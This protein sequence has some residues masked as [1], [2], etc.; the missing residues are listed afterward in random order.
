MGY[1]LGISIA[2]DQQ[3]D[4]LAQ[5]PEYTRQFLEGEMPTLTILE[6]TGIW[7]FRRKV[8]REVP[9]V[10]GPFW[11]VMRPISTTLF[12]R[13]GIYY[14]LNGTHANVDEITNFPHVG[15]RYRGEMLGSAVELGQTSLGYAHAFHS[16]DV[17]IL[18]EAIQKIDEQTLI[19]RMKVIAEE[20]E[21]EDAID[22]TNSDMTELRNIVDIAAKEKSGLVWYW[23]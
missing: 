9:A 23:M 14:L 2:T 11:P 10:V 7:P 4:Y 16:S 21:W 22:Q 1:D 8:S 5:H 18:A 19:Q 15:G 17:P 13:R 20:M 6:I 3:I 12:L